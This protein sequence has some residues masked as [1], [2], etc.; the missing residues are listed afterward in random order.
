MPDLFN[1]NLPTIGRKGSVEDRVKALESY[2]TQLTEQMRFT[3][4]NLD[5]EDNFSATALKVYTSTSKGEKGSPGKSAYQYAKEAGFEG[6]EEEFAL[7]LASNQTLSDTVAIT[8]TET[9]PAILERLETLENNMKLKYAQYDN[10]TDRKVLNDTTKSKGST[11][12][13]L[14][15]LTVKTPA[16]DTKSN[17]ASTASTYTPQAYQNNY[18]PGDYV[19]K[20][21]AN[22]ENLLNQIQ[23]RKFSY[24]MNADPLYQQYKDQYVRGGNMASRDAAAA[25]ASLT[26]GYGSSYATT[27]A[28]QA[29]DN[30]LAGLNDKALD[31]YGAAVD[32]Y[33]AETADL[34]NQL[35]AYNDLE[36]QNY[37][38]WQDAEQ[39]RFQVEQMNYDRWN[40]YQ[41]ALRSAAATAAKY[42]AQVDAANAAKTAEVD[43]FTEQDYI[44]ISEAAAQTHSYI[45]QAVESQEKEYGE[46]APF[47]K[48]DIKRY[49]NTAY[50]HYSAEKKAAIAN[51][52]VDG[53]QTIY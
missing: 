40:D 21:G 43:P 5:P 49:L 48:L 38:Q 52:L 31:L 34:Y 24:D 4:A 26:G 41:S 50:P 10:D 25:A 28:S 6:T 46:Y 14:P 7:L 22:I 32:R 44:D 35:G 2:L 18:T 12:P 47:S 11:K 13:S 20:Y 3:L 53:L 23:N 17:A 45:R 37:G 39:A 33:N 16:T 51:E 9:I 30:Y 15:A 1:L 19:S 29:Y 36:Q 27:A 8:V 42:Q